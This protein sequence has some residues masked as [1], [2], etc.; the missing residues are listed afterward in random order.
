MIF[1]LNNNKFIDE[2]PICIEIEDAEIPLEDKVEAN[3]KA[4]EFILGLEE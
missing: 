3:A 1:D 2:D 4:I